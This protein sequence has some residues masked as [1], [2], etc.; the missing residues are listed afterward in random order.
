M[1]KNQSRAS[2][3]RPQT[4]EAALVELKRLL[5]AERAARLREAA[6]GPIAHA[7]D[8]DDNPGD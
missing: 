1:S 4:R 8:A 6:M 3:L 5:L 7:E 2:R